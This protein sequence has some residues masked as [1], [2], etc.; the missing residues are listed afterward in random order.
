MSDILLFNLTTYT[1]MRKEHHNSE[2]RVWLITHSKKELN[3]YRSEIKKFPHVKIV[4]NVTRETD[5]TNEFI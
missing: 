1:V 5:I 2:W 4:R 3:G